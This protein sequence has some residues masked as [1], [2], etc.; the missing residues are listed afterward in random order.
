MPGQDSTES[1][2]VAYP[3]A[4]LFGFCLA[5]VAYNIFQ[6]ALVAMDSAH[7]EPVSQTI[8]TYYVGQEIAATFLALL[9]LSEPG[10]WLFLAKLSPAEFAQWLRDVASG[11]NPKKYKKHGRGPKKPQQKTPYDPKHPHVSTHRLLQGQS[12][13]TDGHLA[14]TP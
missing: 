13:K 7:Q 10:D 1:L 14:A 6:V 11:V 5:L 8:S 4:A 12:N 2:E 9:M 3:R